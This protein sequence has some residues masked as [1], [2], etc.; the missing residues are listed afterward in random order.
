M[1][2]QGLQ[3]WSVSLEGLLQDGRRGTGAIGPPRRHYQG[4]ECG[5]RQPT[6][7]EIVRGL[8]ESGLEV[9]QASRELSADDWERGAYESGWNARQILAHIASMEWSYPRIIDLARQVRDGTGS[10]TGSM[11]GGNDAYNARQVAKRDRVAVTDVVEEFQRNRAATI[12]AVR[13]AEPD[14][15]SL[16]I[17]SAGGVA[18]PLAT[19]F[20]R[21]TIDHV[22]AHARDMRGPGGA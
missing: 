11:R 16:P 8:E 18:G 17:R 4:M 6:P 15:W 2:E 10:G 22:R 21:V 12:D 14:L 9:V 19:V 20:W 1:V 13:D 3:I 7:E 5:Q